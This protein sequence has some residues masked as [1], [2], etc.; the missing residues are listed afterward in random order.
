MSAASVVRTLGEVCDFRGG[1]TPSKEVARYWDGDIPWVSPKDVKSEIVADSL[2]HISIEAIENSATSLIPPGSILVVVRSGILARI[3]PLAITGRELTI[4]QDLKAL[5]PKAGGVDSRYLYYFLQ[6]KMDCLLSRVTRGATVHRISTGDIKSLQIDIPPIAEQKRIVAILDEAFEGIATAKT[7]AERNLQNALDVYECFREGMLSG[8]DG[9]WDARPLSELCDIRHGYAFKSE[10]FSEAG[11]YTLLTP[12]NFH[13]AGGYRDRGEKQKYYSG[14]IPSGFILCK[15]DLLVAM[16]E[17][18]AG[19]LGSPILVPESGRFLHNQRLGLVVSKPGTPWLN[20]F[21]FHVFNLR[22]IRTEIHG[23][24]TGVKVRHTSPGK[25]GDVVVSFP[26]SLPE[27][28]R[29]VVELDAMACEVARFKSVCRQK[30][31]ALDDLK[32]SLLHHAFSGQ[33]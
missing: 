16:T 26:P 6:E 20:E 9:D 33:L 22:R 25:L 8:N 4:N 30:I 10:Y 15:G 19:L 28:K 3:V 2:D 13:E 21:F 17:Q 1:G 14:P 7:N 23:G 32:K 31:A 12:G 5:V 24:A 29:I 11:E 18:A 27:Q